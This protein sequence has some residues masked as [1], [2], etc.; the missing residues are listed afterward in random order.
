LEAVVTY[1]EYY[2]RMFMEGVGKAQNNYR[3]ADVP[4]MIYTGCTPKANK[5]HAVAL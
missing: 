3:A 2:S 1:E 5:V 4:A